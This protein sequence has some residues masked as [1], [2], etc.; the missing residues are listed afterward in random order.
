MEYERPNI[1]YLGTT[2]RLN[3]KINEAKN[4]ISNITNWATN[5]A[6]TAVENEIPNHSKYI[7]VQ[8]LIRKIIRKQQK[9]L[10]HKQI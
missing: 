9:I 3:D 6:F 2:A 7:T 8:N 5:T 10:L 1:A 4:K